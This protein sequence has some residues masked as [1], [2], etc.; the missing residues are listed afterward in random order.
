M[1]ILDRNFIKIHEI[2]QRLYNRMIRGLNDKEKAIEEETEQTKDQ[3]LYE[4]SQ[5]EKR[6][7]AVKK[8]ESLYEKSI[9]S[10]NG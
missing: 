8:G 2:R 4:I 6:I 9:D 7:A 10:T 3:L 1:S 5:N